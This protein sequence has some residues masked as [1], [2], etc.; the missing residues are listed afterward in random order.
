VADLLA[1][2]G[3]RVLQARSGEEAASLVEQSAEA[4]DLLVTDVVL[5]GMRGPEVAARVRAARPGTRIIYTTG[6]AP[7]RPAA[8][9]GLPSRTPC[10]EKPFTIQELGCLVRQVLDRSA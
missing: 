1:G 5:P 2:A 3:Y 10:L 8:T 6:H 9:P 4:I 7:F